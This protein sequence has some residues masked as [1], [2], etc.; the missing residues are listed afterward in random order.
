MITARELV[1]KR[2]SRRARQF[3]DLEIAP[4]EATELELRDAALAAAIDHVIARRWL[5][6]ATVL[7][8]NLTRS[9]ER[10]ETNLQA[11][12]LVGSAQLL[13]L[14]RV[15]DH[16][17]IN[18]AV[19]IA[20]RLVRPK[21]AGLVNA[22]LRKV[23][24][25]RV[26]I[27]SRHD[28]ERRDELPLPDGRAWR[29]A[30]PVFDEDPLRRLAQ[31]TSHGEE[32]LLRWRNVFG[33]MRMRLL[34]QHNLVHPPII[35]AGLSGAHDECQPHEQPGFHVYDGPREKLG[36]L[37]ATQ[38]GARVQDPGAAAP[39]R[40]TMDLKPKLIIDACA[41]RGTKTIQLAAAHAEARIIATDVDAQRLAVLRETFAGHDRVEVVHHAELDRFNGQADLLVL[42]VPCS[43]SGVLARRVE[44]K[45]RYNAEW[46]EQL[47]NLQR[48]IIADTLH[49]LSDH[50]RLL[51]AT[52]S[53]DEDENEAQAAWIG[54]W[55]RMRIANSVA[56]QPTG[57]P[58][59][60]ANQYADG[61]YFV[62][63][64]RATG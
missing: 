39:V 37:L 11:V 22:V 3:P 24:A 52:C 17:A 6:L 25:L 36:S 38:A 53:I 7:N 12:L 42:D 40:A 33:E 15:P 27:V 1:T 20:K 56:R 35:I 57:E 28:P 23:S 4:L 18:E 30:E 34:A 58:G 46:M 13:L 63:L 26:E 9:W 60:D 45:Y 48:Q 14:D 16:A 19:E 62:L 51:Y 2:I 41:G 32:L 8:R 10:V 50:G 54:K 31:Q 49:L 47:V 59:G 21:A 44:A 64:E 43:N 55:H 29:L 5:T 61:G